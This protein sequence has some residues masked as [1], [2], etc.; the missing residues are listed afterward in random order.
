MGAGFWGPLAGGS[1]G[2]NQED[3]DWPSRSVDEDTTATES[4]YNIFCDTTLAPVVVTLPD[5]ST[6]TKPKREFRVINQT[7]EEGIVLTSPVLIDDSASDVN[8]ARNALIVSDGVNY[9]TIRG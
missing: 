3:Y 2:S 9:Y 8:L 6:F 4:D 1:G 5:P 7:G